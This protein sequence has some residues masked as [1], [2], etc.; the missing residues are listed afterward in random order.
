[1][2]RR[3]ILV[4]IGSGLKVIG[5]LP[6][7]ALF[8]DYAAKL[9]VTGGFP[10]YTF[11]LVSGNLPEGITMDSGTGTLSGNATSAGIFTFTVRVTDLS[12]TYIERACQITVIAEPLTISGMAPTWTVGEA[13]SYTYMVTGGVPPYTFSG[14]NIPAGLTLDE[15]TGELS[16]MPTEANPLNWTIT[17]IDHVDA[18]AMLIDKRILALSGA[19]ANGTIGNVYS[20]DLTITGGSGNYVNPRVIV[21]ALPSGL[22]LSVVDG[23]LRLS[24]TP[25]GSEGTIDFTVAVDSTDGQSASSAQSLTLDVSDPYF[26]NVS[27]LLHFDGANNS[28]VF[29]DQKGATWTPFGDAKIDTSIFRF[30]GAS[31]HFDGT[32]DYLRTPL[33]SALQ[34]LSSPFTIEFFIYPASDKSI[35]TIVS[36]RT[37]SAPD[38]GMQID[39]LAGGSIRVWA[40]HAG[41]QVINFNGFLPAPINT[42]THIAVCRAAGGTWS[43]FVGGQLDVTASE[44]AVA[45]E[46]AAYMYIGAD[47]S[48]AGSTRYWL[49]NIDELRITKGVV[50]YTGNFDPPTS[51]FHDS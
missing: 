32:G 31:G 33:S 46:N 9:N 45:D 34:V 22:T 21:G 3:I 24:G 47:P 14:A 40:W 49:G 20:S 48:G 37:V 16:G 39:R 5:V 13:Y 23:H 4:D 15:L 42:L 12:G 26:A 10:P 29:I 17:V 51:P 18:I 1:M 30:G 50:R 8:S 6:S 41:A 25:G 35:A 19:F 27:A 38:K 43:I 11:D 7:V 28:T 44:T 36:S 2:A